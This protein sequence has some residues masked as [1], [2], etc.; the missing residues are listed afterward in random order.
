ME[1]VVLFYPL[2]VPFVLNIKS[3]CKTCLLLC[4]L[5]YFKISIIVFYN[6][7]VTFRGPHLTPSW[8][9]YTGTQSLLQKADCANKNYEVFTLYLYI[10]WVLINSL[11]NGDFL[12][13]VLRWDV[14]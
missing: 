9:K 7:V 12:G 10:L 13:S 4:T 3:L 11:K 2:N 5:F 14:L 1:R 8:V 6:I